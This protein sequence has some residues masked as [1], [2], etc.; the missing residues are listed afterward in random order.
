[1]YIEELLEKLNKV[2][3]D[4]GNVKVIAELNIRDELLRMEYFDWERF[5]IESMW[6]PAEFVSSTQIRKTDTV[7]IY[8]SK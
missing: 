7:I 3:E 4:F 2:H 1:M 5:N 8:I 6:S